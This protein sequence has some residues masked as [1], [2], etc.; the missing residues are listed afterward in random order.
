MATVSVKMDVE[1]QIAL[2][3][4]ACATPIVSV[5]LNLDDRCRGYHI[6]EIRSVAGE[7]L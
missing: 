7:E 2:M 6:R 1:H 3:C 4:G 5:K